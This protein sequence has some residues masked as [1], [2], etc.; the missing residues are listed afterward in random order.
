MLHGSLLV[1]APSPSWGDVFLIRGGIIRNVTHDEPVSDHGIFL[2]DENIVYFEMNKE[3]KFFRK[4]NLASGVSETIISTGPS[5]EP[6]LSPDGQRMAFLYSEAG[7]FAEMDHVVIVDLK[8]KENHTFPFPPNFHSKY[9]TGWRPEGIYLDA[10]RDK[11]D[12]VELL[13][14]NPNTGEYREILSKKFSFKPGLIK[15]SNDGKSLIWMKYEIPATSKVGPSI[16]VVDWMTGEIIFE[17]TFPQGYQI[18]EI[19]L[20]EDRLL[21][22]WV[23]RYATHTSYSEYDIV[24]G[25]RVRTFMFSDL[26]KLARNG[27]KV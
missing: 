10:V 24:S 19:S 16:Y 11:P 8:T 9:I 6:C 23:H 14:L 5:S 21:V 12:H 3:N 22:T 13:L 2:D 25:I 20:N 18:K 26:S 27:K 1:A 17:T 15:F 7:Y 4:L